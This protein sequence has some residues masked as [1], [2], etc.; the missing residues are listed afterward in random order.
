MG[1]RDRAGVLRR[2]ECGALDA[3]AMRRLPRRKAGR[4]ASTAGERRKG[5]AGRADAQEL[6]LDVV[7]AEADVVAEDD[8]RAR[9]SS[10][11]K[12]DDPGGRAR[13]GSTDLS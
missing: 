7:D 10:A 13:V 5:H 1:A 2:V 6:A 3:N 8:I 12:L 9:L 4:P 11:R